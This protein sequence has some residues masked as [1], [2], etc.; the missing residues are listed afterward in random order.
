[1]SE[2]VRE[3]REQ[4][5]ALLLEQDLEGLLWWVIRRHRHALAT[6]QKAPR[7]P[8]GLF[9]RSLELLLQLEK[10]KPVESGA[11]SPAVDDQVAELENVI[12]LLK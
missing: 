7:M 3:R 4:L 2:S 5:D 6:G 9:T 11:S 1:M 8:G 12:R 10:R